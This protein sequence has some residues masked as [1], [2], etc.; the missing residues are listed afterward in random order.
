MVG[1]VIKVIRIDII[2]TLQSSL[3][4]FNNPQIRKRCYKH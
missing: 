3:N 4:R 1:V 2:L